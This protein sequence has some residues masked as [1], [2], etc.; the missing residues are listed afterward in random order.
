M[1]SV[2]GFKFQRMSMNRQK[3][4]CREREGKKER[5]KF[6]VFLPLERKVQERSVFVCVY[7][8]R[9]EEKECRMVPPEISASVLLRRLHVGG[10]LCRNVHIDAYIIYAIA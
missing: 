8:V 7:I 9:C 1:S 4:V 5:K 3:T 10:W 6:I 2:T